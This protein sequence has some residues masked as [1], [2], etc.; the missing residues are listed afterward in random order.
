PRPPFPANVRQFQRQFAT[1]EA[2][3]HYLAAC[4]WPDGFRCPRLRTRA[5]LH[6]GETATL[7]VRGVPPSSLSHGGDD[8]AQHQDTVDAGVLGRIPDDDGQAWSVGALA[9][10]TIGPAPI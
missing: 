2:C 7:E 9:P 8:P 3:Q 5:R 1:E 6:H 4:R 10:A